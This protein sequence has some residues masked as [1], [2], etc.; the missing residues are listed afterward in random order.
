MH[1]KKNDI[2][3]SV[4]KM[5]KS[6]NLF[7]RGKM[8]QHRKNNFNEIYSSQIKQSTKIICHFLKDFNSTFTPSLV[9]FFQL[10][11]MIEV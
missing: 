10:Y 4:L 6:K 9:F 2:F 3:S 7:P 8:F 5:M 1:L 11:I